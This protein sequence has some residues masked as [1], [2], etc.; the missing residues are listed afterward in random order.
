MTTHLGLPHTKRVESVKDAAQT[1]TK[2]LKVLPLQLT[3][4]EPSGTKVNNVLAIDTS[5]N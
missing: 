2:G 1:E 4:L 5:I 3:Q